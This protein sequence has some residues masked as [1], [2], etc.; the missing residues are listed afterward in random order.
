[1]ATIYTTN[2]ELNKYK[3]GIKNNRINEFL[4]MICFELPERIRLS[5]RNNEVDILED[6]T[7][8]D[9]N[10]IKKYIFNS[11][12]QE[13]SQYLKGHCIYINN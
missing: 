1:M 7:F 3:N 11:S 5:I 4:D 2:E 12:N 10:N 13:T 6:T 8:K 9:K